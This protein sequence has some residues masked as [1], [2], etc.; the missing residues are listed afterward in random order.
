M[1]ILFGSH[2]IRADVLDPHVRRSF[3]GLFVAAVDDLERMKRTRWKNENGDKNVNRDYIFRDL[4]CNT[5]LLRHVTYEM[6]HPVLA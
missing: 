6:C 3:V 4:V 1:S 2:G 5:M